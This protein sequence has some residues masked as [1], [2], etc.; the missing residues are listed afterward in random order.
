MIQIVPEFT[1][2]PLEYITPSRAVTLEHCVYQLL[3]RDAIGKELIP[4]SANTVFGTAIHK[5]LELATKQY[6]AARADAELLID[7]LLQKTE[8]RCKQMGY[9][10]LTPL[11]RNVWHYGVKR[12]SAIRKVLQLGGTARTI[13]N[14]SGSPNNEPA[15]QV[16]RDMVSSRFKLRGKVDAVFNQPDGAILVDYKTGAIFDEDEQGERHL[17]EAYLAQMKLYAYLHFE[18][19]GQFP[20]KIYLEP[21]AG[22]E[23][24]VEI[25]LSDC[26]SYA[27]KVDQRVDN[28]NYHITH[29]DANG[30]QASD[31]IVCKMC[32]MRP[33]CRFYQ[34]AFNADKFADIFGKLSAVKTLNNGSF[35]IV[36]NNESG[37]S[38][39]TGLTQIDAESLDIGNEYRFFNVKPVNKQK[40]LFVIAPTTSIFK[41]N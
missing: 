25:N 38:R 16:E 13:N 18:A 4:P 6:I 15:V 19:T 27:Q 40:P 41:I 29:L 8:E 10:F 5:A 11:S 17:K 2:K 22:K 31:T 9:S 12:E 34:P 36:L 7:N 39:I 24:I 33:A 14:N 3:L 26:S 37:E 21:L 32:Q 35:I 1:I 30:L 23:V 28:V 20:G